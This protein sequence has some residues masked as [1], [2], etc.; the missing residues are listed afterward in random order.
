[1]KSPGTLTGKSA[2]TRI[3]SGGRRASDTS[4]YEFKELNWMTEFISAVSVSSSGITHNTAL[5]ST[6]AVSTPSE[7][8]NS[9]SCYDDNIWTRFKGFRPNPTANFNVEFSRLARH[10]RWTR[11]ER[12]LHR[13]EIFDADSQAHYGNDVGDFYKRQE[14]CR[15]CS[16]SPIL[17]TIP[18]CMEVFNS[19]IVQR[20]RADSFFQALE[21]ILVNIYDV[22]DH[23][24]TGAPI[25][26]HMIFKDFTDYTLDGRVISLEKAKEDTFM[27]GF[28]K[29]LHSERGY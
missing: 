9:V 2:S 8:D 27:P 17:K 20:A 26:P 6:S 25:T 3:I 28:L 5:S 19:L 13:I 14:L 7:S 10:Q 15:L 29:V 22:L 11:T 4:S 18:A 16:I 21:E 1:V 12:H 23:Q 24:R